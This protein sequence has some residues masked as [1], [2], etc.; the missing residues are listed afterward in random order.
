LR[1]KNLFDATADWVQFPQ[2]LPQIGAS[3]QTNGVFSRNNTTIFND[4]LEQSVG[5]SLHAGNI[6][7]RIGIQEWTQM[8]M[9]MSSMR[10]NSAGDS[11]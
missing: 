7:W 10:K 4:S 9:S 8:Q 3:A 1:I 11:L 5:D 6:V 2:L